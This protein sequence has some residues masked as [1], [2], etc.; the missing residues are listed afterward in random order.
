VLTFLPGTQIFL[1]AG[2]TDMRL[3]YNGLTAIV[4]NALKRDPL[5]GQIFV[6]SNRRRN[7]L[8][9]L[10]WER[11]GLWVCAKRLE[12]GTFAWPETANISLEL[13]Q[14]ELMMLL[15][16]FDL[17]DIHPRRWYRHPIHS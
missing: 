13:S 12:R 6:F 16:G 8:K 17:R 4:A 15:G 3:S 2:P 1:V 10:F 5:G 14:E 9:V 7:R 11:G